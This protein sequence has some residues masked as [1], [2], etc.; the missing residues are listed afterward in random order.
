MQQFVSGFSPF[1][2]VVLPLDIKPY[3]SVQGCQVVPVVTEK[4]AESAVGDT[5]RH[6]RDSGRRRQSEKGEMNCLSKISNPNI[7]Y[8]PKF[9]LKRILDIKIL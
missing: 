6:F 1:F 4:H 7:L 5:A 3:L 2:L 8:V 9:L